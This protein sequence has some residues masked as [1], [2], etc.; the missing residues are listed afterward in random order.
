MKKPNLFIVGEPKCGTTSLYYYLKQHPDIFM[1]PLKEPKFFCKDLHIEC[2]EHWGRKKLK[3]YFQIT[4]ENHYSKLFKNARDEKILGEAS[5]F[6]LVSQVSAKEI[7]Q[8]NKK[9]KIIVSFREPVSQQKSMFLHNTRS[10]V[11]DANSFE[12]ALNLEPKRRKGERLP[13][14]VYYPSQLYY[15]EYIKYAEHLKR[16]LNYFPRENIKV[17]IFDDLKR[18]TEGVYKEILSFLDV[19]DTFKCDFKVKNKRGVP[20]F[21]K[22]REIAT[23]S[24]RIR[25]M[26][27][28]I[29]P[30]KVRILWSKTLDK[31]TVKRVDKKKLYKIPKRFR[32]KLMKKYKPEVI[33]INNLLHE[34]NLIEPSKDLVKLWG[35]D[36]I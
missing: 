36:K 28:K 22:L 13:Q 23:K 12:E 21:S 24:Y 29:L 30:L 17:V 32:K 8:F 20:R 2:I 4:K 33:K 26:A 3:H 18:D 15:S 6:Y 10:A 14:R 35:Y 27:Q 1:S 9:A 34:Y 25:G 7:Y 19:D 31:I 16:F 5:V 11:E